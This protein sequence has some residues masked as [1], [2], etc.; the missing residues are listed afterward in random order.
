MGGAM[1][2]VADDPSALFWN[3]AGIA[4]QDDEGTQ[5]M[6]GTT[7]ITAKQDFTGMSPFPG[8]GYTVS[9]EDQI[10]F[11][12]HAYVVLPANDAL[13]IGVS[14]TTP[15]GLGTYWP[16]DFAGRFI[17]KR[18]D[19]KRFDLSVDLA[20][21]L[22][23]AIAMSVGGTYAMSQLDLTRNIPYVNP[24]TQ[25]L[26][27]VGQVHMSTTGLGNDG[28]GWNA[29]LLAKLGGGF[30]LGVLY[31]SEIEVEFTDGFGSFR[32]FETGY[33]DFDGLLASQIPFGSE[34]DLASELTFPDFFAIGLSWQNEKWTVSGQY[35]A[36]GW[37]VFQELTIA[38]PEYPHLNN[39]IPENYEDTKQYR[40]GIE[41]RA[42]EKVAFQV[43]GLFDET[44][45]PIESMT[46][47]LGDGDRTGYCIGISFLMHGLQTDIGYMYLDFDNRS[48]EG[49]SPEGFDGLYETT[50]HLLG[51]TLSMRF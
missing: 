44:P 20:F 10:F 31:R 3:P 28:Y 9:Q 5:I 23:N 43:G 25:Q 32:Q 24:Y 21:K 12:P 16:D 47:L 13:S 14:M 1:T 33:A 4:F 41:Y 36:M 39:T 46:P 17:S 42:S 2:A 8:D 19:I 11:P 7:F 15:Y 34:T 35:G 6:L 50:A 18:V 27:D 37:E 26:T 49:R 51:A 45:Q 30:Q 22:G 40:L 48:T 29:S 38:F